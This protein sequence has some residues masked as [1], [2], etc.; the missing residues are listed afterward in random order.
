[1]SAPTT[2]YILTQDDSYYKQYNY[3]LMDDGVYASITQIES[4]YI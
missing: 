1:M 3:E 2:F 4:D